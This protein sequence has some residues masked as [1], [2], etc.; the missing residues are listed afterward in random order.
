MCVMDL[1]LPECTRFDTNGAESTDIKLGIVEDY[2]VH[3]VD[4]SLEFPQLFG[5][6]DNLTCLG[7][8]LPVPATILSRGCASADVEGHTAVPE[9]RPSTLSV[10]R[11]YAGFTNGVQSHR[12]RP[13]CWR[14]HGYIMAREPTTRIV[15]PVSLANL[16][17]ITVANFHSGS[18]LP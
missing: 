15:R 11:D 12:C 10:K 18:G 17:M 3:S 8:D 2:R 5:R 16:S 13:F 1:F 6:D 7:I 4:V 9:V 14:Y